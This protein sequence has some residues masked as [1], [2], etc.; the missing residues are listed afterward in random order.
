VLEDRPHVA[1]DK[2][3]A[4]S[5]SPATSRLEN[6]GLTFAV[7]NGGA[8]GGS[9]VLDGAGGVGFATDEEGM[10]PAWQG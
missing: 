9:K 8:V 7:K 3:R 6:F 1:K 10:L 2:L 4:G 5:E